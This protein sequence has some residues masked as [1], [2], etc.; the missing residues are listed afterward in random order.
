MLYQP[1]PESPQSSCESTDV[2][3]HDSGGKNRDLPIKDIPPEIISNPHA[4]L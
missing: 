3:G 2:G 4:K 1:P